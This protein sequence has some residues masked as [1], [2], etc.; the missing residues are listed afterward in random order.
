MKIENEYGQFE[1]DGKYDSASC[2]DANGRNFRLL[3]NI[4]KISIIDNNGDEFAE[5]SSLKGFFL[6]LF[7]KYFLFVQYK[8]STFENNVSEYRL[9]LT[10]KDLN[11]ASAIVSLF[12]T[13]Q[14]KKEIQR[15]EDEEALKKDKANNTIEVIDKDGTKKKIWLREC[16]FKDDV[17]VT[18]GGETYHT[19][20]DCYLNWKEEYKRKFQGWKV[21]S[22]KDAKRLGLRECKLCEKY[23][24]YEDE[25]DSLNDDINDE[26]AD[27]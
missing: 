19:H 12:L 18:D 22:L 24:D 17:L 16:F 21:I 7:K 11:N 9:Q 8:L 10:K 1:Y 23:Y 6:S 4:I 27:F 15:K 13:Y 25:E 5:D 2:R 14:E 20:A 26:G 3:S